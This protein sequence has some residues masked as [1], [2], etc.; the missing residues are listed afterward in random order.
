MAFLLFGVGAL[1]LFGLS[2]MNAQTGEVGPAIAFG[3]TGMALLIFTWIYLVA[4]K[5]AN[6]R[7]SRDRLLEWINN[8]ESKILSGGAEY[9]GVIVNKDTVLVKYC[10]VYSA[11]IFTRKTFSNYCIKGSSRSVRVGILS[12][13][14]NLFMGW[15]GVPWGLIYTPQ[16]L[17]LNIAKMLS[18]SVAQVIE[19]EKT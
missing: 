7:L 5:P 6:E 15:W 1:L 8:N 12:T 9:N 2:F 14:F 18:V 17:Y 19:Q 13:L 4:I 3:A 10:I 11:V 16:S